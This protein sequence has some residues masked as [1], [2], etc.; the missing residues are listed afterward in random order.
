VLLTK[1]KMLRQFLGIV[2]TFNLLFIHLAIKN[3]SGIRVFPGKIFREYMALVGK[4]KL[5]SKATVSGCIHR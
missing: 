3:T 5:V 2:E 4:D 1:N